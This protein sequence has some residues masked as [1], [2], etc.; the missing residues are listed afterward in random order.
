MNDIALFKGA[1]LTPGDIAK[2]RDALA[3]TQAT[4]PTVG[5]TPFLK[6]SADDG[7][8]LYGREEIEVEAGSLWAVNPMSMKKGY[9]AW[10]KNGGKPLHED[11]RSI[12]GPLPLITEMPDVGVDYSEAC[13]MDLRC[14]SG[15]D[16]GVQITWNS[17]AQGA[18]ERF[19]DLVGEIMDQ[20]GKN[21]HF[22]V[23]VIQLLQDSY[24]HTN[25]AYGKI[26]KPIFKV[27]Y[28]V[29]LKLEKEGTVP[30]PELAQETEEDPGEQVVRQENEADNAPAEPEQ[31][32]GRARR[33]AA[34]PAESQ[35]PTQPEGR[36][37]R[38]RP[39]VNEAPAAGND[40]VQRTR[41]RRAAT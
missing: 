29:N 25:R 15:E 13:S 10:P 7:A 2:Y 6:L 28:F 27:E 36:A 21:P 30:T 34:P 4:R 1:Q 26:Y 22:L 24:D 11:V 35:P 9:K 37:R 39:P 20:L 14:I 8:W 17:N 16:D 23:P 3:K 5:G 41:R 32:R 12:F 33:G 40:P 19:H 38:G 31:P 18:V